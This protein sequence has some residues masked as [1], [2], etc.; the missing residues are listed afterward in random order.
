MSLVSVVMS[1]HN[2]RDTLA[3]AV[4]SMLWQ[5]HSNWELLLLDDGST[6]GSREMAI[7]FDDSRIRLISDTVCHGLPVRL[8]QG[9]SLAR[10]EYIARM[11]ADDIAFPD[12]FARQ[13]AFL[14]DNPDVDL[15]ATA[16]LL[17]TKNNQPIGILQTEMSHELICRKSWQSFPM[18]HPTW[19]GRADWFR[20]NPYDERANKVEDQALLYRSHRTAIFAG[21][22]DVL[23][24]YR[25]DNLS[26]RKTLLGR[27]HYLRTLA[28]YGESMHL[29]RGLTGH[30]LAAARDLAAILFGF[31]SQVI[32][33][34]V[35]T[36]DP[37]IIVQWREMLEH[38]SGRIEQRNIAERF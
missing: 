32:K 21:L 35:R 12:R 4:E 22:P 10:G 36:V 1:F 30:V 6:D 31:E 11:D 16:A 3:N 19:M 15:L 24:A 2:A 29:F 38:L 25:Y 14:Q 34:R 13:V 17:I 7:L 8:N 37:A 9:I 33:S 20:A 28:A 5:S 18:P 26:V 23:L 27:Y